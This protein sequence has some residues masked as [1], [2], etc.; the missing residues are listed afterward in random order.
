[1]LRTD[2]AGREPAVGMR[3]KFGLELWRPAEAV[4]IVSVQ[5]HVYSLSRRIV[6]T[7]GGRGPAPLRKRLCSSLERYERAGPRTQEAGS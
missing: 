1:M 7:S 4:E 2:T 5:G 6:K 3:L